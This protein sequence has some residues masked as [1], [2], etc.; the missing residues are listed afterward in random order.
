VSYLWKRI[1]TGAFRQLETKATGEQRRKNC[2]ISEE[3]SIDYISGMPGA[4]EVQACGSKQLIN[5]RGFITLKSGLN[6]FYQ[7]WVPV[8]GNVQA[9]LVLLHG[10]GDHCDFQIPIKAQTL[11]SLEQLACASFDLPGH[12]RSDGLMTHI[13]DWLEFV[14]AA[15]EVITEHLVPKLTKLRKGLK[16]FG[17]GDS[18]GGGVLFSLLARE[19]ELFSGAVLVCPMLFV[20]RDMFPPWL[21]VQIFKH[22]LVP[23]LPLWPVAP[24]KDLSDFLNEDPAVMELCCKGGAKRHGTITMG[25]CPP[26]LLTAYTLAFVAGDWMKSKIK[27]YDTPSLII[28]GGGDKITD[29]RV[30]EDLFKNMQNK[31]KE[32]LYPEGVWHGDLFHGGP[33]QYDAN[34]ERYEAVVQWIKK[35][36]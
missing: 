21:V 4:F 1:K 25:S 28:H 32:L 33:T 2:P 14:D 8:D 15:R 10:Y 12:G 29:H 11:C 19:R 13:P 24:S 30:S 23:A 31:D 18:M 9:G 27:D 34:K 22:L 5:E 36:C 20:S 17:M 26:R 3:L 6:I 7:T 16:V 35:R